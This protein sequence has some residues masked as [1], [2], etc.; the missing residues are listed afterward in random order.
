MV[1]YFTSISDPT[2]VI[3]MG[4]DKHE[5]EFL[6]KYCQHHDIWF[7][8]A[9]LSSAHVYLRMATPITTYKDLPK[10]L[11]EECCQLT[12]A[13]SIEGCKKTDVNMNF[14]WAKNLLKTGDMATGAV[15]YKKPNQVKHLN[16]V[17]DKEIIRGLMKTK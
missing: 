4:K 1:Y 10:A 7:H 8:V 17:K 11:I 13:N 9:N 12:K 5:N 2:A 6:I 3:Y 14:T 15:S 16:V